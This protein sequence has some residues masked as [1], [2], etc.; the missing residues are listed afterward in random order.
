MFRDN[1]I[2]LYLKMCFY[3]QN[4]SICLFF[5]EDT[6]FGLSYNSLRNT[7]RKRVEN[8]S[9]GSNIYSIKIQRTQHKMKN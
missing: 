7:R 1:Q 8:K 5:Q 9:A 2:W 3:P 4:F 6:L